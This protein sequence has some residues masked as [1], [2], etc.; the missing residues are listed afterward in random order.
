[1]FANSLGVLEAI[2]RLGLRATGGEIN[3]M[4]PHM[5]RGQVDRLLRN[6]AIEGY[7]TFSAVPY[8]RTGKKIW[9]I[10]KTCHTN[11]CIVANAICQREEGAAA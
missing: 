3:K 7:A 10:T 2:A 11:M 5:T 4:M 6:L 1:M 9:F 8:G